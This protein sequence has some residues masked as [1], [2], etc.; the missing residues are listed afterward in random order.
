MILTRTKAAPASAISAR[1][2]TTGVRLV[3][4]GDSSKDYTSRA[5]FGTAYVMSSYIVSFTTSDGT[6]RE[7]RVKARNHLA[8]V[9]MAEAQGFVIL[10]VDRDDDEEIPSRR[11]RWKG[12]VAAILVCATLAAI[13][14]AVAWWR[15]GRHLY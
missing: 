15:S 12:V 1:A 11:K 3:E 5:N 4:D 10:S 7:F 14:V 9:R 2:A 6:I 13:C 8:A